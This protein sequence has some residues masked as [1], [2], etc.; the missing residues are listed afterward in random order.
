MPL[1]GLGITNEL[2]GQN[3]KT[4]KKGGILQCT[5]CTQ[6]AVVVHRIGTLVP[7]FHSLTVSMAWRSKTTA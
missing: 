3:R 2:S 6:F 7:A 4:E 5:C 1:V